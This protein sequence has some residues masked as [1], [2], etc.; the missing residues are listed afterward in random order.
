MGPTRRT[1]IRSIPSPASEPLAEP[2]GIG[3]DFRAFSQ[4]SSR[5]P[6]VWADS[7]LTAF[8]VV[9]GAKLVPLT[10][11]FERDV[12]MYWFCELELIH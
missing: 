5:S 4:R 7:Y 2:P 8:A 12:P 11:H 3:K 6:K 1:T 10:A 9:A